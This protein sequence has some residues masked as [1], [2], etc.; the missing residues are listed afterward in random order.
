MAITIIALKVILLTKPVAPATAVTAVAVAL[1][2]NTR[3]PPSAYLGRNRVPLAGV[4]KCEELILNIGR[5][6]Y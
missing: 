4:E 2:A 1:R 3:N 6:K 5:I